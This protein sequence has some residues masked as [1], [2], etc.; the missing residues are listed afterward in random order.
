MG[1][2]TTYELSFCCLVVYFGGGWLQRVNSIGG[3]KRVLG[4]LTLRD[5]SIFVVGF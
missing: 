1:L 2:N 5:L 3:F 4:G